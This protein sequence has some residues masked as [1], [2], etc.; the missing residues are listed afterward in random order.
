[1]NKAQLEAIGQLTIDHHVTIMNIYNVFGKYHVLIADR[2]GTKEAI[3][4]R[5]GKITME[6]LICPTTSNEK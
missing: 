5:D 2:D 1:M 4:G 6:Y 3:V